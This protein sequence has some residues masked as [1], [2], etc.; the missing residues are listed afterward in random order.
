VAEILWAAVLWSLQRPSGHLEFW[1][2]SGWFGDLCAKVRTASGRSNWACRRS[3]R[4]ACRRCP[5]NTPP[6]GAGSSR[7][8]AMFSGAAC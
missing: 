6:A 5:K 1:R 2:G 7:R 3:C 8:D 4:A